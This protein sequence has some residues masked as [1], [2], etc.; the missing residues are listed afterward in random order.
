VGVDVID[1]DEDGDRGQHVKA[2]VGVWGR[3][4]I[5]CIGRERGCN[6]GHC[7][8][9]PHSDSEEVRGASV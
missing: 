7:P 4:E 2:D 6:G 1:R 5:G 3:D 8:S 9:K